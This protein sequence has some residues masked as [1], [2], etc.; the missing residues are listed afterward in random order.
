MRMELKGWLRKKGGFLGSTYQ[1]RYCVLDLYRRRLSYYKKETDPSRG[2]APRGTIN[3]SRSNVVIDES[4]EGRF[5]LLANNPKASRPFYHFEVVC[6]DQWR[7]NS[8]PL[9]PPTGQAHTEFRTH[10]HSHP[11]A[12]VPAAVCTGST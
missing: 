2:I 5:T 6:R 4:H 1:R 11:C 7:L 8:H 3:L 9:H 12:Y 10:A